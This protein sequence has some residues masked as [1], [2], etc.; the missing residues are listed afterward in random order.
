MLLSLFFILLF[1]LAHKDSCLGFFFFEFSF[2]LFLK[3]ASCIEIKALSDAK[4]FFIFRPLF[5]ILIVSFSV[6]PC[7]IGVFLLLSLA[8][9]LETSR[10]LINLSRPLQ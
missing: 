7:F 9:I 6:R 4:D 10:R 3:D 8:H 2:F 1:I 5:H